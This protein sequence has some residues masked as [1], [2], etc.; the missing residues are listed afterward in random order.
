MAERR[1]AKRVAPEQPIPAKVKTSLPARVVDISARG[2]QLEVIN[3]LR[4][5]VICELRLQLPDGEVLV[6]A[7]VRRCRAWGFGVDERDQR[8]LLYRAGV[9]F[10]D[11]APEVVA[12]I[13]RTLTLP[14][15]GE[16]RAVTLAEQ[17]GGGLL[18]VVAKMLEPPDTGIVPEVLAMPAPA[19]A[20]PIQGVELAPPPRPAPRR[21][22]P[23]KVRI[24]SEHVRRILDRRRGD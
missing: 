12:R 4:P 2:A 20:A 14:E 23:V 15:S 5:N 10:Q 24:S 9:E 13:K 22:G 17:D 18:P 8:V 16:F 21:D 11:A 3:C 1:A 19:P 6:R 7:N